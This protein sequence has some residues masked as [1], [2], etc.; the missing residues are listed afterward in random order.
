VFVRVGEGAR[1]RERKKG[2][3]GEMVRVGERSRAAQT[4]ARGV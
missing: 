3:E 1:E 2:R 4:D